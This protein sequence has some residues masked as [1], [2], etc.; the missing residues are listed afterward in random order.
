MTEGAV[1][2][3]ALRLRGHYREDLLTR[4]GAT[5]SDPAEI[6]EEIR[7]LFAAVAS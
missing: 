3:A 2:V 4:I 5:V 1:Q 7:D 6:E